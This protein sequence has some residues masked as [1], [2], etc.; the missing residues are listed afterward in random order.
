MKP[1]RCRLLSASSISAWKACHTRYRL[2]YHEGL[3]SDKDTDSQRT[4]TNWH[5]MW[6]V[7]GNALAS[8]VPSE[9]WPEPSDASH[10]A[11]QA[12]TDHLNDRYKERPLSIEPIAWA[13]ER[14]IL[15]RSFIGYLWYWQNDPIKFVSNE[16]A[17]D[18]PIHMP[19]S[20]MPLPMDRVK[21]VGKIDHLIFWQNMLG[22]LERKSTSRSIAPESDYWDKSRKDTQVSMYALALRDLQTNGLLPDSAKSYLGLAVSFGSCLYDV[23]HKPTIKP[24]TLTQKDTLSLI[25]SGEYHGEKFEVVVVKEW[26]ETYDDAGKEKKRHCAE[27]TVDGEVAVVESG[28]KSFA[29]VETV[30][31]YGARLLQDI[32]E[33]PEFYFARR[34]IPRTDA[35]IS[36]FRRELWCHHDNMTTVEDNGTW[37]ENEQQCRATFACQFIPICYGPGAD[38]VCDGKTTPP[39]F[40]RVFVDLTVEGQQVE[41]D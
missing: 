40:K 2:A 20:G 4:G 26:A 1:K 38:A 34:E 24:T 31:M 16:L 23:W 5:S 6:E 11:L 29:L 7:Y 37:T 30:G 12:V 25:Q 3:R 13:V 15:I 35:E 17:F 27:V 28:A 39:G 32:Y 18:L 9:M 36:K 41:G 14:A 22:V 10:A 33:R 19:R 21:R 8:F